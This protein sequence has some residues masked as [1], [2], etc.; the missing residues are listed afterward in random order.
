M[1]IEKVV[2]YACCSHSGRY[3][4]FGAIKPTPGMGATNAVCASNALLSGRG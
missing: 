4:C 3:F 2:P 1:T